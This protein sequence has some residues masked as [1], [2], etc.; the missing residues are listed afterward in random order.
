M[1]SWGGISLG[2]DRGS[3]PHPTAS[4]MLGF[5]GACAGIDRD[6]KLM[7]N[8]WYAGWDVVTVSERTPTVMVDY[9]SSHGSRQGNGDQNNNAVISNRA[10]LLSGV[11]CVAFIE[12][13]VDELFDI[14]IRGLNAPVFTP[15]IGRLCSPLMAPPDAEIVEC[16]SVT[17]IAE[18]LR[19]RWISKTGNTP[20]LMIA[21]AGA[22]DQAMPDCVRYAKSLPD[23]RNGAL[24]TH[25]S[26]MREF[27]ISVIRDEEG[28]VA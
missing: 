19:N 9:Q 13:N 18:K 24:S 17:E 2:D 15:Y 16:A 28:V 14:A 25:A 22:L 21:P 8:R 11:E 27:H 1:R 20:F 6:D 5:L 12:R 23:E 26:V 4:G 3:L 10:Y 7:V